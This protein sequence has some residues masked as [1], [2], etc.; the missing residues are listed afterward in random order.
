M[1]PSTAVRE[2]AQRRPRRSPFKEQFMTNLRLTMAVY[3]EAK[4]DIRREG[5]HVPAI[6]LLSALSYGKLMWPV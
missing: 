6:R 4:V 1:R 3:L 2:A 5:W